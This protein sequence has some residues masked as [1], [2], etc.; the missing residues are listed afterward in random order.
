VF[1]QLL[2]PLDEYSQCL[3]LLL[4]P[5]ADAVI[6]NVMKFLNVTL[7]KRPSTHDEKYSQE[8]KI[9]YLGMHVLVRGLDSVSLASVP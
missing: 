5:F 8:D 1:D 4:L 3:R 7:S 6:T 9:S 2:L